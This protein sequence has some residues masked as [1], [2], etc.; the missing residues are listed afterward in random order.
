MLLFHSGSAH[1]QVALRRIF[2]TGPYYGNNVGPVTTLLCKPFFQQLAL[3][4]KS[5]LGII[6]IINSLHFF[7]VYMTMNF[8]KCI[9]FEQ[10]LLQLGS[11]PKLYSCF[12]L[13]PTTSNHWL[14]FCPFSIT[15]SRMPHKW[16]HT[17]FS[18]LSLASFIQ[19]N[20]SKIHP[21]CCMYQ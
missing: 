5:S 9:Q 6:Y 21:R 7:L 3:F 18:F 12:L 14:A 1:F 8:D 17:E 10:P 4:L 20:V 13:L 15:F 19:H 16:N 2:F 11:P